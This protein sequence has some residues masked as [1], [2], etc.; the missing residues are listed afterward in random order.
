RTCG[1]KAFLQYEEGPEITYREANR[2]AN[3]IANGLSRLG[4]QK[5]DKVALFVPNSLEAV[6]LWFG[7]SKAGAIDVPINLANK[8]HFLSHQLN[9]SDAKVLIIDRTF[10][11]RLKVIENDL[12]KIEKV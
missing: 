11:D 10:T 8:G 1:D 6:Y 5:G 3:G 9:D 12:P 7:V 2:V 4:V